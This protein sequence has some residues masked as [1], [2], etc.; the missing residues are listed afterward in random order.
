MKV[1]GICGLPG[2]GKSFVT[3]VAKNHGFTIFNMG[4]VIREE[5]LKRNMSAGNVAVQLRK[6][7]GNNVVAKII[8][9]KIKENKNELF[10]IEGIRSLFEV[11]F[12]EENF[13]DF[14][15]LSIFSSPGTR[16]NR[17]KMRNREDD[18]QSYE[19]FKQRDEREFDFGIAKVIVCSDYLIINEYGLDEYKKELI[20]FFKTYTNSFLNQK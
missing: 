1:M 10:I 15:I 13:N 5:A 14:K 6:E 12:F 8:V 20:N 9:E 11:E 7:K 3:E 2:S 19:K 18:S 17:L 16:F 4:D